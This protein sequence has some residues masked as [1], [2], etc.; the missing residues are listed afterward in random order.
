MFATR[1]RPGIASTA[2]SG[3]LLDPKIR[4]TALEAAPPLVRLSWMI[5]RRVAR[6]RARQ[7]WEQVM[8]ALERTATL[9]TTVAPQ[10]LVE[11]G[12]VEPPRRRRPIILKASAAALAGAAAFYLLEPTHGAEHRRQLQRLIVR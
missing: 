4:R 3:V 12:L 1:R 8:P 10:L 5:G 11:L 2:A 6:R 7:R 9:L